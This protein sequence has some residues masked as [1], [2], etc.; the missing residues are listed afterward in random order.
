[1]EV[2]VTFCIPATASFSC[3][4]AGPCNLASE[5]VSVACPC[6]VFHLTT[7]RGSVHRDASRSHSKGVLL[8]KNFEDT[9]HVS[10]IRGA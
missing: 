8:G 2:H 3:Q 9:R 1:M 5:R 6:E 4:L 7:A 10:H